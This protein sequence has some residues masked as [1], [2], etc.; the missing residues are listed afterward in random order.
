MMSTDGF[1]GSRKG[2]HIKALIPIGIQGLPDDTGRVGL[3]R[4]HR[5]DSEWVRKT[6][7]FA[8]GQAICGDDYEGRC[9]KHSLE[10]ESE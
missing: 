5:D 4:I 9:E 10:D 1:G 8:L 2:L 3:F 6:K 7:Y